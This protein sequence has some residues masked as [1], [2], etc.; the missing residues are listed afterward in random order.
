MRSFLATCAILLAFPALLR[1]QAVPCESV[2]GTMRECRVGSAGVIRMTFEM[3]DNRCIEGVT[4]GT[5]MAGVV[6]V[7]RGC[8]AM[9]TTDDSFGKGPRGENRVICESE[10]G[11]YTVCPA[12]TAAGVTL[13]RQLSTNPCVEES[14]WGYDREK[15]QIWVDA[16]CRAEFIL[17]PAVA[18]GRPP[19]LD[20]V[21][22]CQ[23]LDGR[24]VEC[25]ADTSAGVQIIRA[26]THDDCGFGKEWG[27]DR[28][29][30]WVTNGCR[31]AFAVHGSPKPKIATVVCESKD[32]ARQACGAETLFGVALIRQLSES[33]CVLDK[34]WGFD[35]DGVW[36]TGG[37][38]AQ[39]ALG[40]YRLPA[41]A[42][43]PT[44]LHVI[45]DSLDGKRNMC[46]ADTAHGVGLVRQIGD[47]DC[48]LNRTWGY[49]GAGIWVTEG[50]NAEFAVGR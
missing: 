25:K 29:G 36:V 2:D 9:F 12:S 26:F 32:D 40:G 23:S 35:R 7:S 48:I 27:Y 8:R 43:P 28:K 6:Y 46:A 50:C 33:D 10:K 42:V 30:V 20:G 45:C 44:A 11:N 19:A 1:A 34:T 21:V 18:L 14:T 16:G 3:S 15:N 49:D 37:C 39:F 31:A 22:V 13:S 38:R 47:I 5:R 17:G 41:S 24:R 4:W